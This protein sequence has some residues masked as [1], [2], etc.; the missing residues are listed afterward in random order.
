MRGRLTD[1]ERLQ[2]RLTFPE[3]D[4]HDIE[5]ANEP[6]ARFGEA[7]DKDGGDEDKVVLEKGARLSVETAVA[8]E[9]PPARNPSGTGEMAGSEEPASPGTS[10]RGSGINPSP[11][12][13]EVNDEDGGDTDNVAL[14]TNGA[15]AAA[16][17]LQLL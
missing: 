4:G 17:M 1:S 9:S 2:R 3:D 10:P 8:Y 13:G 11:K 12:V 7:N 15:S 16:A 14:L 5:V 6:G